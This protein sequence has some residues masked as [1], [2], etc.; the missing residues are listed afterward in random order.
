MKIL[1]YSLNYA[2]E[3]TGIG[4]YSGEL[5]DWLSENGH[6]VRVICAPPYY[7][8]WRVGDG[9][10]SWLYRCEQRN[11]VKI[12]RCPLFVP[13]NPKTLSRLLHLLSFAVSSLP[14]ML[15]QWSWK[16]DVVMVI[17]PTFL[18]VPATLLLSRVTGAKSLLHIQDFELD[19]MLGLGLAKH[20]RVA[21]VCYAVESFFMLRF[22]AISSISRSMLVKAAAKTRQSVPLH[23]FPN[24]VDTDFVSPEA[25]ALL[26]RRRW[27]LSE[28]TQVVLYSGNLGKKQGLDLLIQ[29][30]RLL[31][32]EQDVLF[33]VLGAGVDK[34]T[35]IDQA[36]QLNL[37]NIRFESLQPYPDLPALMAMAD[38]HLVI[39][40][41]GVA[42]AVLPSK[43]T[44]ILSAGGYAL[45]TA[46]AETELGL[47]CQQFPGIA[48]CVDPENVEQFVAALRRMLMAAKSGRPRVNKV[49]RQYAVEQLN[50]QNVLQKFDTQLRDLIASN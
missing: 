8:E 21:A 13:K 35:L 28:T 14:V 16:P 19:A 5:G 31:A 43:L 34:Q 45:I 33:L 49:A 39:Q 10:R 6:E 37:S 41:Q 29:A 30:A 4:K 22:S 44:T 12:V 24:W 26:F 11:G 15:I 9:Y 17:E 18:C 1:L 3:L 2:P 50:K 25:D 38:V 20:G 36:E 23:F 46:E 32:A 42:D 27:G 48:E 40:K 47:L 7:P